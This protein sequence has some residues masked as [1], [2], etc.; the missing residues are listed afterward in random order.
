LF[1]WRTIFNSLT[2]VNCEKAEQIK[3]IAQRRNSWWRL[4]YTAYRLADKL[5]GGL[6]ANG[7]SINYGWDGAVKLCP[8]RNLSFVSKCSLL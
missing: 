7:K 8:S 3:F 4:I 1:G 6:V 2:K 5:S